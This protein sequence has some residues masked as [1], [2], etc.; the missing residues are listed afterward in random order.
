MVGRKFLG[1]GHPGRGAGGEVA[2]GIRG[3]GLEVLDKVLDRKNLTDR[4]SM[5]PKNLPGV[6]R[7]DQKTKPVFQSSKRLALN[8]PVK[9]IP[10]H[11]GKCEKSQN[12]I[13]QKQ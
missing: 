12:L 6:D 8:F 11:P 4:D 13:T 10:K 9:K 2:G 7:P 1:H 3:D 5:E